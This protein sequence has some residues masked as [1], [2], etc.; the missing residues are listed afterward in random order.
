MIEFINYNLS[1]QLPNIYKQW[2]VFV[3]ASKIFYF[4][5][6]DNP[7]SIF[8]MLLLNAILS[9]SFSLMKV[10]KSKRILKCQTYNVS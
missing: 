2:D 4:S 9:L 3:F 5:N 8:T 7:L 6:I 10:F 1:S